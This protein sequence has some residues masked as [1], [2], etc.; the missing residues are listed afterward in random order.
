MLYIKNRDYQFHF[1]FLIFQSIPP[2]FLKKLK[3]GIPKKAIL[4]DFSGRSWQVGME[5]LGRH[6]HFKTGWE[7]FAIDHFLE[8]GDFLIFKYDG[9]SLFH[10]KIFGLNGCKKEVLNYDGIGHGQRNYEADNKDAQTVKIL[11][12]KVKSG[13]LVAINSP[14]FVINIMSYLFGIL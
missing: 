14:T 10:V 13:G 7:K 5:I 8:Y 1:F 4:K 3:A 6:L 11:D 2:A 9:N 12:A